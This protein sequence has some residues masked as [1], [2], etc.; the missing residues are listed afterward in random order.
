MVEERGVKKVFRVE[1][2]RSAE[3][4]VPA[5]ALWSLIC[6]WAG[7]LRWWLG[8]DDGGLPRPTLVGCD[9]I[10]G[11]DEVPR[12][13]RMTLDN[14]V[15]VEEELFYQDDATRRIYYLKAPEPEVSGC[16]ATTWV[17][18]L[19]R[20]RSI[21]GISS[22]MDVHAPADPTVISARFEAIYEAMFK[23]YG[24]YFEARA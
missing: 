8:P 12:R 20:T 22:R 18:A 10:G 2:Q 15:V 21:V 24:H 3:I 9:L 1:V 6:D 19:D 11:H 23:G 16:V 7:M 5:G 13:R 14:R 4:A 17:D